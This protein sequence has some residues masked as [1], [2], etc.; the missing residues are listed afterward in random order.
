MKRTRYINYFKS[1]I[2]SCHCFVYQILIILK[3]NCTEN[4]IIHKR[5]PYN[6][7]CIKDKL[8]YS[9]G[10]NQSPNCRDPRTLAIY[11][12]LWLYWIEMLSLSSFKLTRIAFPNEQ[13][14]NGSRKT[15]LVDRG[16]NCVPFTKYL[17]N[18]LRRKWYCMPFSQSQSW[19]NSFGKD[20]I[21]NILQMITSRS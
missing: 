21:G 6:P 13:Y 20:M 16:V 2:W 12:C 17:V 8:G 4:Q 14:N 11:E 3:D 10:T 15:A 7:I 18:P 5:M 9:V 19:K 1:H